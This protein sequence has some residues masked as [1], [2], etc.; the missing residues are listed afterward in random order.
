[1][2]AENFEYNKY[3]SHLGAPIISPLYEK[4]NRQEIIKKIKEL[5][6]LRNILNKI[7]IESGDDILKFKYI[8]L[9]KRFGIDDSSIVGAINSINVK[10]L[11]LDKK[12][13][14]S[15]KKSKKIKITIE[16]NSYQIRFSSPNLLKFKDYKK[17]AI[18]PNFTHAYDAC[19]LMRSIEDLHEIGVETFCIH[20]SLGTKTVF[21]RIAI[22]V[23][24]I[25]LI[26]S[27]EENMKKGYFPYKSGVTFPVD[28]QKGIW[29]SESLFF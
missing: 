5:K 17:L 20:D 16:K 7:L 11:N 26:A 29:E 4:D 6:F 9:L 22:S 18:S 24:K 8:N 28:I 1:M 13:K 2:C 27:V 3:L 23:Y 15:D 19:L 10:L 21:S 14:D 25:N 12:L